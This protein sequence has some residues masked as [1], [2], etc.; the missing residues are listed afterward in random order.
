MEAKVS[1]GDGRL[2]VERRRSVPVAGRQELALLRAEI[3]RVDK[4]LVAVLARRHELARTVRALKARIGLLPVD[5]VR[6]AAI[7]RRAGEEARRMG[8]PEEAVRAVFWGVL[9]CCREMDAGGPSDPRGE[10]ASDG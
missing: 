1:Q 8:L 7:V 9:D 10:G 4:E 6:E 2:R 3:D 5:P